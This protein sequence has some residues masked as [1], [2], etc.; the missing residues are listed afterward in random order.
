MTKY[1]KLAACLANQRLDMR[2][3]IVVM[4]HVLVNVL[5]QKFQYTNKLEPVSF[6][7]SSSAEP[8]PYLVSTWTK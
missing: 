6:R 3:P 8:N 7:K 5:V 1:A 2:E 4:S